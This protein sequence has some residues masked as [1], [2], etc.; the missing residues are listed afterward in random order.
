MS[1]INV[2]DV[3]AVADWSVGNTDNTAAFQEAIDAAIAVGVPVRVPAGDH[4]LKGTLVA[5]GDV[6]ILGEN[7]ALTRLLWPDEP[8]AGDSVIGLQC[9]VDTKVTMQ[10]I[11]LIG[12]NGNV[13]TQSHLGIKHL[14]GE[15]GRLDIVR[16]HIKD[17]SYAVKTD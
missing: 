6:V 4:Y 15:D 16:V 10:D 2:I 11:S 12:P 17:F 1:Q 3:G 5:Q 9:A 13:G 7:M 14:G 8:G